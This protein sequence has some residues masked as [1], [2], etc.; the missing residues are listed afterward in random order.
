[1]WRSSAVRRST[2]IFTSSNRVM[3]ANRLRRRAR[4]RR[5]WKAAHHLRIAETLGSPSASRADASLV[6]A[7]AASLDRN[8]QPCSAQKT[9]SVGRSWHRP[10]LDSS[11]AAHRRG[12]PQQATSPFN[13]RETCRASPIPVTSQTSQGCGRHCRTPAQRPS[14]PAID[15]GRT[16][17]PRRY[18]AYRHEGFNH[19][20]VYV[21]LGPSVR[22][23]EN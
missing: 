7:L 17:G 10:C 21:S 4:A 20:G 16:P 14:R 12:T 8:S 1:M 2:P 23:W 13:R 19:H 22:G 6:A 18:R 15:P 9:P 11:Q 3:S 5:T